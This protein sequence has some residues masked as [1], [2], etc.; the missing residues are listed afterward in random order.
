MLFLE[1]NILQYPINSQ[2]RI[3][4]LDSLGEKNFKPLIH[5]ARRNCFTDLA[6]QDVVKEMETSIA[7]W[8]EAEAQETYIPGDVFAFDDHIFF[9]VFDEADDS[10]VL[11]AGIIYETQTAEPFRKLDA[12]CHEVREVLEKRSET[13]ENFPEWQHEIPL[14]QQGFSKFVA[15]QD[16]DS[17]YT[18]LRKETM[19]ARI[20][21]ASRLEDANARLFLRTARQAHQ[22]GYAPKLLNGRTESY[23]FSI[24]RLEDAG[25]VEREVQVSCRKTGHALF[26]LPNAHALAVVTVSDATCSE[27]GSAVADENV[28]EVVAPTRLAT[29]LLE[30]GSW[31]IS[32]LHHLLREL[33]V[34]EREI[35]IGPA[36]GTG[37][38]QMLANICGESFLML[39]RDGDLTP[40]FARWA[41][42]LELET[43]AAHLV[44]VATGRLHK[45][46][47]LLLHNHARR[48]I[49]GGEDF[50]LILAEDVAAVGKEL[51]QALERV[52]QR[53][54]AEQL[55]SL[56]NSI[57][58]NVSRLIL[59]KFKLFR[60]PQAEAVPE[61]TSD[62]EPTFSRAPLTLAAY[63]SAGQS[64]DVVDLS[65]LVDEREMDLDSQLDSSPVYE[66]G[67]EETPQ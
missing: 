45:E 8:T 14:M 53:V 4:L 15:R 9:V 33:G 51:H 16:A 12:F 60:R 3:D 55:C 32:R 57:G 2:S 25:L 44:I 7:G 39:T 18:S 50:E 1:S 34:P 63:A 29:S 43:E 40:A 24:E 23:E 31:L 21:A 58:L 30:D 47:G 20:I 41:I 27:C 67:V 37:Y 66:I 5:S 42:D 38:G 54:V 56:D 6:G 65:P 61:N 28:E 17:L 48:R 49:S 52:S 13:V 26:R 59:T 35:A 11:R 62:S 10:S 36:E 64:H 19:N 22:E 46:A